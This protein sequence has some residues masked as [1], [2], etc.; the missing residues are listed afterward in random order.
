MKK[1]QAVQQRQEEVIYEMKKQLHDYRKE[2]IQ[3]NANK[4]RDHKKD[5]KF[6]E[7]NNGSKV[8]ALD[9]SKVQKDSEESTPFKV[10]A[11]MSEQE[12]LEYLENRS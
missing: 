2:I 8:P 5:Q 6:R 4:K 7:E 9:L 11:G 10:P 3:L 1:Q 12:Y